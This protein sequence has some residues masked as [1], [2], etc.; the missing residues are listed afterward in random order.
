[1]KLP[2]PDEVKEMIKDSHEAM[3]TMPG[4]LDRIEKL[5]EAVLE[6]LV[7]FNQNNGV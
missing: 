3:T 5:L 7:I 1:M 2:I 6:E 4:S